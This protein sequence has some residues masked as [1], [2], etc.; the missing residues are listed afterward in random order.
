[1]RVALGAGRGR[2]RAGRDSLGGAA[3][4]WLGRERGRGRGDWEREGVVLL[5]V[6]DWGDGDR[7]RDGFMG[8]ERASMGC[9][10]QAWEGG[11]GR[12]GGRGA[13]GRD[14]DGMDREPPS[15]C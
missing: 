14:I 3:V 7:G 11:L 13:E 12:A 8:V 9:G 15:R 2:G 5:C 6:I 10:F 4:G 1:M